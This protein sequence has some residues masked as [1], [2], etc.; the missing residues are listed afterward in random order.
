MRDHGEDTDTLNSAQA[1]KW[2]SCAGHARLCAKAAEVPLDKRGPSARRPSV[3]GGYRDGRAVHRVFYRMQGLRGDDGQIIQDPARV[4]QMLWDSR[5]ELWGSAPPVPEL[6][7]T[8][9]QAYFRDRDAALPDVPHPCSR[10]IAKKVLAA[11]GS[12]PGHNG[13][14]Y[15]AYHQ[16]IELVTETLTLAVLAAHHD[17][18][19]LDVMLGPNV[20][21]LFWIPKKA[22]ADRPDGQRPLQL[23]KCFRRLFGSVVTAMVAPQVE[24][25]FS[26]WQASVKGGS[27]AKKIF[28]ALE[29]LGGS[30]EPVHGPA[31]TLWGGV[32]GDAAEGAEA[33]CA[34][35]GRAGLR[36]CPAVVR[37]RADG[38]GL[39]LPS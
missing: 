37:L 18:A 23:P 5:K 2:L 15:E 35:A 17:P 30:D 16:G 29:H 11:G 10:D 12:A 13:I 3:A 19:V 26:E 27:C 7:D 4:D 36:M 32:L 38:H 8:I 34:Q 22:G 25:R 6:A 21:L 33:A 31:G 28:R 1:A 24:L 20:D 39:A 14:P 9:L